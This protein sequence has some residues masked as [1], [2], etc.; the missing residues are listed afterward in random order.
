MGTCSA[1]DKICHPPPVGGCHEHKHGET[2]N[3]SRREPPPVSPVIWAL[4]Y[5]RPSAAL[6]QIRPTAY[7]KTYWLPV[8]HQQSTI[9]SVRQ[10]QTR[11]RGIDG[12]RC[13]VRIPV[14]YS[15]RVSRPSSSLLPIRSYWYFPKSIIMALAAILYFQVRLVWMWHSGMLI[16]WCLSFV[17]NFIQISVTVTEIDALM[18]QTFIDDVT[19]IN[20]RSVTRIVR[21]I[22]AKKLWKAV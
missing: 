7:W 18:L 21:M 6:E 17:T 3:R 12:L 15:N 9:T 2:Y 10:C 13:E 19:W 5:R 8:R 14:A 1:N 20:F 16:V 22:R 4:C 11:Q